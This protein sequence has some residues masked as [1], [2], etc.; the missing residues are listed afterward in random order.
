MKNSEWLLIKG[1]YQFGSGFKGALSF[2]AA[3]VVDWYTE[4][5]IDGDTIPAGKSIGDYKRD[6]STIDQ[7]DWMRVQF[8]YA[9]KGQDGSLKRYIDDLRPLFPANQV[10]P[11]VIIGGACDSDV[12]EIE[13]LTRIT[14]S[15]IFNYWAESRPEHK[16][17]MFIDNKW[18]KPIS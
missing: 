5:Y 6:K 9:L 13:L 16:G 17:V 2:V 8:A 4:K 3:G 7:W 12:V 11:F 1:M 10:S 14:A 15:G 18:T